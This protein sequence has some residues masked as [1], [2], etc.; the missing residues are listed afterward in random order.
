MSYFLIFLALLGLVRIG[1]LVISKRNWKEH[2]SYAEMPKEPLFIWMVTLHSLFFAVLPLEFFLAKAAFGGIVSYV[3]LVVTFSA[4]F[5]RF[6]T[7]KTIGRSWNVRVVGAENYPIVSSGPY[8]FIRHPNYLVVILEL[9]FIPLIFNLYYSA[10][11]LTIAN[12]LVLRVRIRNE[13]A[14]LSRNPEW[15]DKMAGKPRFLPGI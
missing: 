12:A 14:V 15:V 11:F 10:I 1:E 5:L 6:W 3:G 8:R 9:A 2:S 4:F 13:E 7:L